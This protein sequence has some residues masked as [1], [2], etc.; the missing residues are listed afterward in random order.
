MKLHELVSEETIRKFEIQGEV[1]ERL[2]RLAEYD[3]SF[4]TDH[5]H[6]DELREFSPEQ[7]FLLT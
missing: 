1:I 5:F 4:L 7:L 3:L 2:E 6:E